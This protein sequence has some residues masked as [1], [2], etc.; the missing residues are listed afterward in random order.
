MQEF[1]NTKTQNNDSRKLVLDVF[2]PWQ[3]FA[4]PP[5][6][7]PPPPPKKK[8]KNKDNGPSLSTRTSSGILLLF[9]K[10]NF[11]GR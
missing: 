3:D 7:P 10:F 1:F 5:P 9:V 6:P 8:N 2:F 4:I 11:L